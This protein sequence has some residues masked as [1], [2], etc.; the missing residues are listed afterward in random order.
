MFKRTTRSGSLVPLGRIGDLSFVDINSESIPNEIKSRIFKYLREDQNFDKKYDK[1]VGFIKNN[2]YL[3]ESDK[4]KVRY[5]LEGGN[6]LE[7]MKFLI[8]RFR[9]SMFLFDDPK[10]FE[11]FVMAVS[12]YKGNLGESFRKFMDPDTGLMYFRK[13]F[14]DEAFIKKL[15]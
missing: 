1:I 14:K 8:D 9:S 7:N 4:D 5:L 11:S 3:S 13:K 6:D 15:N 10:N 2:P 12:A